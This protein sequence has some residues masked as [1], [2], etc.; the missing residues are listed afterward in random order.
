[1]FGNPW[2]AKLHEENQL[3]DWGFK[4]LEEIQGS[5]GDLLLNRT[6][7]NRILGDEIP[8]VIMNGTWKPGFS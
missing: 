4:S 6:L 8:T 7:Q 1:M 2:T 3:G 5:P